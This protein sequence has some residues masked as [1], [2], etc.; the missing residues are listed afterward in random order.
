[1]FSLE[2]KI[3]FGQAKDVERQFGVFVAGQTKLPSFSICIDSADKVVD[4]LTEIRSQFEKIGDF[5]F[6]VSGDGI[7][8]SFLD[9]Y[10]RLSGDYSR[11]CVYLSQK[12]LSAGRYEVSY[13]LMQAYMYRLVDTGSFMIHSATVTTSNMGILFCG[14]SGA[15]KSTQADLWRKYLRA[16]VLN[17]DKP[18]VIMEDGSAIVHGSPWSGKE[19][20]FINRF[21]P[22]KAI[23]FI[24]Q[25]E[26]CRVERLSPAR[27][28]AL[29]YPNNYVYPVTS[30]IEEKY[31]DVITQTALSVPVYV[32]Y[33]DISETAVE[34]LYTELFQDISYSGRKREIFVKYK[35]KDGFFMNKIA[36]E[37]IVIARGKGAVDFA[38]TL[39]FNETGAF[40]WKYMQTFRSIDQLATILAEHYS[41]DI[42][43]A[44]ADVTEFVN[45]LKENGVL[46]EKSEL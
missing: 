15:G 5:G 42:V 34:T 46:E 8:I 2:T 1:M 30:D 38:A 26:Q 25:A 16:Y 44:K 29:L 40:L 20:L 35:I 4:F 45:K 6:Y 28:Y 33:C 24:E 12:A 11:A 23:V 14:Y 13:L 9:S 7:W 37:H 18:C 27:A 21:A 10:A 31:R 32:L 22:V 19:D 17:Y 43:N 41:L 36:D 39:V 3:D